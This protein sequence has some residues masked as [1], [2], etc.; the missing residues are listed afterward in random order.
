MNHPCSICGNIY[1]NVAFRGGFI[2]ADC[3][4]FIRKLN[5]KPVTF[6]DSLSV[7][8]DNSVTYRPNSITPN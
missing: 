7:A 1:K 6:S 3:R 8:E 4:D 5:C 2:C